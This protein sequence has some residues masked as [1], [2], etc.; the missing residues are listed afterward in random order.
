[1]D[2]IYTRTGPILIAMN[3]FKRLP[4]YQDEI[5]RM[6][7]GRPHGALPPHCY[8][9]VYT[10]YTYAHTLYN[11]H[12]MYACAHVAYTCVSCLQTVNHHAVF[13]CCL[14]AVQQ[15]SAF[16]EAAVKRNSIR[17]QVISGANCVRSVVATVS[18]VDICALNNI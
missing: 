12:S 13:E 1:M 17:V 6:Y 10:L 16:L 7:H 5:T 18:C 15:L 14:S 9:E 8:Q 4:I 2:L 11:M 3:P